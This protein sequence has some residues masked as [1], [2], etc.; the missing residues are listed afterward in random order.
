[1]NHTVT[2]NYHYE[3]QLS[4]LKVKH[5]QATDLAQIEGVFQGDVLFFCSTDATNLYYFQR[6]QDTI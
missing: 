5:K 4:P 3:H 6:T 2:W 1:M